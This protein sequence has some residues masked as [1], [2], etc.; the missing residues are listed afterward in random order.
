M[1]YIDNGKFQVEEDVFKL[2]GQFIGSKKYYCQKHTFYKTP[3]NDCNQETWYCTCAKDKLYKCKVK[4]KRN[5][6]GKLILDLKEKGHQHNSPPDVL[7]I[8]NMIQD[9]KEAARYSGTTHVIY[10]QL[11]PK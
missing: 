8:S 3:I 6:Q 9:I 5:D 10:D 7:L 4:I 11:V 1:Y 2:Q